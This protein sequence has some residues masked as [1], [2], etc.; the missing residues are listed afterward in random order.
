METAR[1]PIRISSL[2]YK[3]NEGLQALKY[4]TG[5]LLTLNCFSFYAAIT[6]NKS[7]VLQW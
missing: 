6:T 3:K 4:F 7:T 5:L 2:F 1:E